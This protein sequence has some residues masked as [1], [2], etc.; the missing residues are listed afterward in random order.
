MAS[1]LVR[2]SSVIALA[3]VAVI[4]A[5]SIREHRQSAPVRHQVAAVHTPVRPQHQPT[6][7]SP[8]LVGATY[9]GDNWP[10]NFINAF[11][12]E[13]VASDYAK[14][15]AD[16]FNAVV[17]LVSWGDFQP[18]FDP[19]CQ[20]D[21]RAFERLEFLIDR[22][23]EAGLD[24]VLRI[25]YGWTF[26]PDAGDV[27]VRIHRLLN[28]VN[29]RQAF[30]AYVARV[31]ELARKHA[32]VRLSFLAWEDFI[33]HTIDGDG[34]K[35]FRQFIDSLPV[36]DTL[37]ASAA[38]TPEL[39]QRDGPRVALF[40]AYWDWLLMQKIFK[41]AAARI[42]NLTYEARVDSE[43]LPHT[44]ADGKVEYEWIGHES[45]Y[46][47][48]GA[49]AIALYWAPFWGAQ[50][51]GEQLDADQSLGLFNSLLAKV[52]QHSGGLP[53]FID[54]LNVIDNTLGFEHNATLQSAALPAFMDGAY[55]A[56]RDAGVFGYAF[57][58]THD[59]AE[60]PLYNPSFSY[61]LDGW[62]LATGDG[63]TAESHLQ[64]RPSGDFDLR[65]SPGD[66]LT[67]T[68]PARRGRLPGS[69]PSLPAT[70][71]LSARA[72]RPGVVAAS[73]GAGVVRLKFSG[74]KSER[75]CSSIPTQESDSSINLEIRVV[76]GSS[77]LTG[78]TLFDHVQKGG[79]YELDGKKGVLLPSL[80]KLN[81]R[82]ARVGTTS[83]SLHREPEEDSNVRTHREEPVRDGDVR[84]S[85]EP[86]RD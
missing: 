47:P 68:I 10:K 77:E 69:D 74:A 79:L 78:V 25:G 41:P 31:G 11:R 14:L 85:C 42:P 13:D 40:N 75:S 16:G 32:N 67:Q 15:R 70:I 62:N 82:F 5:F 6:R 8:P 21:E 19:C 59:Y 30:L 37:R 45:T 64:A 27:G 1:R 52:R 51:Q 58:T 20:Y 54:Q 43:P 49:D 66:R 61:K 44:N 57:W 60:S 86:R 72:G 65:L 50:N 34:R 83:A 23:R 81:L 46:R 18:V 55:C 39:P 71:C 48:P 76:S 4:V 12:R 56:M 17:L 7:L 22:A 80:R 35:D 38:S 33:L 36:G 63:S 29:A 2:V 24:V 84:D 26:H 53:M 73:A 28:D 3:L 9:M